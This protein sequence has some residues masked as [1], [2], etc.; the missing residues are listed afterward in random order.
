MPRNHDALS[1]ARVERRDREQW[2]MRQ[3]LE[4][5]LFEAG[6]PRAVARKL[7]VR[8]MWHAIGF[9]PFMVI[10]QGIVVLAVKQLPL[11]PKSFQ[12]GS[13]LVALAVS[14]LLVVM[15]LHRV[16]VRESTRA[17]YRM[18]TK[19]GIPLCFNC[20]YRLQD[21]PPGPCPECG[22]HTRASLNASQHP[23]RR[24]DA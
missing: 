7:S 4:T 16:M 21:R 2:N 11:F 5:L 10:G 20:G 3:R 9:L 18:S 6:H 8:A 22:R 19:R 24:A 12:F 1:A 23:A 14:F 15:P 17:A 13:D